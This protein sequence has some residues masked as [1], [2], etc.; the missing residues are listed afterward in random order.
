MKLFISISAGNPRT[1]Y[2]KIAATIKRPMGSV[3]TYTPNSCYGRVAHT[4]KTQQFPDTHEIL[5]F[6]FFDNSVDHAVLV[7]AN[8]K[9][10]V[11]TSGGE[12]VVKGTSIVYE[13]IDKKHSNEPYTFSLISRMRLGDFNDLY[14][15]K[16]TSVRTTTNVKESS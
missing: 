15:M 3:G 1:V 6:S 10:I 16:S 14:V 12:I 7:D 11:D 5:L 13:G 8:L 4:L 9:P 2:Q